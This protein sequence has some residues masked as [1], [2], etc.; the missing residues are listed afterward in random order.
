MFGLAPFAGA[1]F[2]SVLQFTDE[3]PVTGLVATTAL[4][5]PS[6]STGATVGITG[7]SATTSLGVINSAKDPVMWTSVITVQ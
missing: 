7:V 3:V 4:G 6:V 1:P 2:S 5:N